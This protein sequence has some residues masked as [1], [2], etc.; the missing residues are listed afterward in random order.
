MSKVVNGWQRREDLEALMH[1]MMRRVGAQ[2]FSKGPCRAVFTR[3]EPYMARDGLP[4]TRQHL[5]ISC[6]DRYPTWNEIH[7]ARYSLMGLGVSVVMFLPPTPQYVNI[8]PNCFH[9]YETMERAP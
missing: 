9:L 1:E 2:A 7:D 6:E 5:S 4:M 8:H 3:S